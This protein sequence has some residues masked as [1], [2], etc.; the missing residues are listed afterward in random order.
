MAVTPQPAFTVDAA[1]GTAAVSSSSALALPGTPAS[2]TVV[3]V[4]N[5]GPCH[6]AIKLGTSSAVTV[7]PSTGLVVLA[8]REAYLGMT[9]FTHIAMACAGGPGTSST[10]NIATGN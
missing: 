8:G 7:T 3:L 9:G 2:D 6:V 10:L 5:L 4:T 1:I